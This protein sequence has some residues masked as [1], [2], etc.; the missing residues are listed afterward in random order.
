MTLLLTEPPA[1]PSSSDADDDG[2]A[3]AANGG[4]V[5]PS[6]SVGSGLDDLQPPPGVSWKKSK[7]KKKQVRSSA[8]GKMLYVAL[9][10]FAYCWIKYKCSAR[11]VRP[12]DTS[13]DGAARRQL[14][15]FSVH[16]WCLQP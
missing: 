6:S 12:V 5:H 1:E 4:S 2:T 10:I 14:H 8:C 16:G 7:G 15:L 3:S 13:V 9:P 11:C